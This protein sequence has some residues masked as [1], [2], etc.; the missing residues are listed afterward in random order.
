VKEIID[1][2][3]G[4]P[5]SAEIGKNCHANNAEMG[6]SFATPPYHAKKKTTRDL[7]A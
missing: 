6:N 3:G 4:F 1:L 5:R 7:V 2:D